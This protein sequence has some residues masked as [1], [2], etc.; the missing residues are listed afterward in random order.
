M[1][2]V[3]VAWIAVWIVGLVWIAW[4]WWL[5]VAAIVV[6]I[7]VTPVVT[8]VRVAP[9]VATV[10]GATIVVAVGAVVVAVVSVIARCGPRIG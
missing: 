5:I 4:G 8:T 2:L 7:R 9:I 3:A 6:A 1:L 10:R